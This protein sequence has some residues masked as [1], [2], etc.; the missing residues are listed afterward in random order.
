MIKDKRIWVGVIFLFLG[1]LM[2]L[3]Q[4]D[5]YFLPSWLIS[6]KTLVIAVGLYQL[7]VRGNFMSGVILCIVGVVF[8]IPE[9]FNMS[10]YD[11]WMLI[12]PVAFIAVGI[13]M[14][15]RRGNW[16]S[17]SPFKERSN[18]LDM[19]L[20]DDIAVFSGGERIINSQNFKGGKTLAFFGGSIINLS[21]AK[22][23][24]EK[25]E[26]EVFA[27]FGGST[28]IVPENWKVKIDVTSIFGG[29]ADRRKY[30]NN[31]ETSQ[32]NELYIK[33]LVVFGGG[34]IKSF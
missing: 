25:C 30:F 13:S 22:L 17:Q 12:I 5:I 2:L 18:N 20:I 19:D 29:F 8:L 14:L 24:Q 27:L 26:I 34:E 31:T 21:H 3:H 10:H 15:L 16:L 28:F 32:P 7:L 9:V 4:M 23:S 1:I 11:P 33:G 6:W